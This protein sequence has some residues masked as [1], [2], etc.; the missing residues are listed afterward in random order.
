MSKSLGLDSSVD[1]VVCCCSEIK[2]AA[3]GAHP[4]C[5]A[6]STLCANPHGRWLRVQGMRRTSS[7]P[8]RPP[9]PCSLWT[10]LAILS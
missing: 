3:G 4:F 5:P 6:P 10:R 8:A 9:T 1:Y 2:A 7:A